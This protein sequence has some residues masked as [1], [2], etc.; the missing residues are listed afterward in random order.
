MAA[1]T[2]AAARADIRVE[3][4]ESVNDADAVSVVHWFGPDRTMR[5]DGS[6]YIITRL[7][8]ERSYVVDRTAGTYRVVDLQLDPDAAPEVEITATDDRREINGWPARR[9][10]IGGPAA[11][12]LR[13]DVWVSEAVGVDIESFRKLMVRLGNRPGSGWM[14]AYREIPGFPVLQSVEL[15]RPGIQL[16]SS[17]RV[18]KIEQAEPGPD[19]YTPPDDY[20]RVD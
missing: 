6:R 16:R 8:Q 19:T 20:E 13:I 17:S 15:T 18:V 9:Y 14:K 3:V 7:D 11:R 1:L 4:R 5:D 10:R 2:C 12:E